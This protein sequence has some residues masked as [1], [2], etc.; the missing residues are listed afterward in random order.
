MGSCDSRLEIKRSMTDRPWNFQA[1]TPPPDPPVQ[2]K[3]EV[4]Q[5]AATDDDATVPVHYWDTPFWEGL[6]ALGYS[7]SE[8]HT[9]KEA[10]L[11]PN[12]KPLLDVMRVWILRVWRRSVLKS[13]CAYMRTTRGPAWANTPAFDSDQQHDRVAGRDCI[14]K[15]I[16]ADFW[17]WAG[18]SRLFF[19]RW[20]KELRTW[21]RDVHPIYINGPLPQYTR[22]QPKEPNPETKARVRAKLQKFIDLGYCLLLAK[23]Y[24][25]M[26]QCFTH[27][28]KDIKIRKIKVGDVFFP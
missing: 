13:F 18:G 22:N 21:A 8:V 4:R 5:R 2:F 26:A 7:T 17:D 11:G 10:R 28:P 20:P 25:D 3:T 27:V 1:L 23:F 6:V 12:K 16:L 15:A 24:L 19:W 9:F 14:R